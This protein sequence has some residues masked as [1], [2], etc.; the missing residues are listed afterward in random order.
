MFCREPDHCRQRSGGATPVSVVFSS[1]HEADAEDCY[2]VPVHSGACPLS[3]SSKGAKSSPKLTRLL[4]LPLSMYWWVGFGFSKREGI[5]TN[6]QIRLKRH[7]GL[8]ILHKWVWL[9][10]KIKRL[11]VPD[12][13][14]F[15]K[16]LK[17]RRDRIW[18]FFVPS[19]LSSK[20]NKTLKITSLT[21]DKPISGPRK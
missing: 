17:W 19:Q 10:L 3:A 9:W 1:L 6:S 20:T 13:V 2:L 4:C 18:A 21:R 11:C 14:F 7:R 8:C 16:L 15:R 5:L 12:T